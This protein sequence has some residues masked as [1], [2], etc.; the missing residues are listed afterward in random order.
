MTSGYNIVQYNNKY[1]ITYYDVSITDK[2]AD[3]YIKLGDNNIVIR[4][5][6]FAKLYSGNKL[7]KEFFGI[8][9]IYSIKDNNSLFSI[10]Y[11]DNIFT[12]D[13]YGFHMS[14]KKVDVEKSS[15]EKIRHGL[16]INK[17]D[18]KFFIA[19]ESKPDKNILSSTYEKITYCGEDLYRL[20][21]KKMYTLYNTKLRRY[22]NNQL[23]YSE[24][25]KIKN[26]II[27]V[28][29]TSS[30]KFHLINSRGSRLC[31]KVYDSIHSILSKHIIVYD[32][33]KLSYTVLNHK[34]EAMSSD[35][36]TVQFTGSEFVLSSG[37]MVV[38]RITSDDNIIKYNKPTIDINKLSI[39]DKILY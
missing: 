20:H 34:G 12:Y 1:R 2:L 30:Q 22:L 4:Y 6:K 23:Y 17:V 10:Q 32:K 39:V 11:E 37:D 9:E 14:S 21:Y 35:I 5:G 15:F 24:D 26:G 7:T 13:K 18:G 25:I 31:M 29:Y 33:T 38:M 27:P 28:R 19:D 8:Y 16:V 36:D 3:S